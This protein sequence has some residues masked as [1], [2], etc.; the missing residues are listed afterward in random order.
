VRGGEWGRVKDSSPG[1]AKGATYLLLQ[2]LVSNLAGLAYFA[3]A[4]A[5]ALRLVGL[6]RTFLPLYLVVAALV[7]FQGLKAL[8]ALDEGDS[9]VF[10]KFV[11]A[12]ISWLIGS[13]QKFLD[14][15]SGA[16]S[17]RRSE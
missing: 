17:R 7:Y 16:V 10:E 5:L 12:R 14:S 9:A 2:G 6:N 13:V 3:L 8:K 1:V 4:S 11:P 15:L